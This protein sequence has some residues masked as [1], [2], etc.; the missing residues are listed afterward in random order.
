MSTNPFDNEDGQ[1]CV[2][3]NDEE[4]YCL[5]PSFADIPNGW[6]VAF[7]EDS[8]DACIEYVEKTWTDMRPK[9]LREA[10]AAHT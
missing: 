7:G 10:M 3:I 4:Q 8:R 6:L 9:S 1:F 5:W 2:L